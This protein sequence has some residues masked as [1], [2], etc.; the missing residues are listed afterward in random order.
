MIGTAVWSQVR[1]YARSRNFERQLAKHTG[2]LLQASLRFSRDPSASA[3][4]VQATILR[5]LESRDQLPAG[6]EG[7]VW[8]F[9][10]MFEVGKLRKADSPPPAAGGGESQC[11]SQGE[12]GG[13]SGVTRS[14][15]RLAEEQRTA[16]LLFS[17][18][19]FS[20]RQVAEILSIPVGTV[21]LRIARARERLRSD[22]GGP[23]S[24]PEI[25]AMSG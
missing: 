20:C 12:A 21:I 6:E 25:A 16:L 4:I 11:C 8:L 2:T 5:A 3:R 24:L 18:Y 19:G 14:I 13:G 15:D 1:G 9:R 17:V 7:K 22:L 10:I 23:S